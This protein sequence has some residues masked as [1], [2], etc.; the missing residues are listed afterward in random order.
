LEKRN[1]ALPAEPK[2]SIL[3][4]CFNQESVITETV[5]SALDQTYENV[6]VV[7][8]DD[9]ST[10]STPRLLEDLQKQ[11]HPKLKV[12]LNDTNLGV[13]KNHT[14]GLLECTGEYIAFLDGDDL[15]LPEKIEKQVNFMSERQECTICYHDVDV[16]DSAT[17][18]NLYLWS[19]RIGVREGNIKDLVRF[20]NY[21]PAVAVMVRKK[22]LPPTGYDERI[23]VYSDWFLWL[24]TLY[25]GKGRICYMDEVLAKYRR[26]SENLTNVSKWKFIDQNLVLDLVKSNWPEYR[27]EVRMRRSEIH[28][29][30]AVNALFAKQY[31][32]GLK[33]LALAI[34]L[35]FPVFPWLRLIYREILFFIKNGLRPD[36][37]F[38]SIT[39]A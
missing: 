6:E 3:I 37:I 8:S 22:D 14:R 20:G 38:K 16:F 36:Y 2:V 13:T 17:G 19:E 25:H 26:H 29:M 30:Q 24:C 28:F 5:L 15:F 31:K 10:D 11:Y 39:S 7:V 27:Y 35:G 32:P 34:K 9:A 18:S 21:L 33:H 1:D 23:K 12:F 4:P